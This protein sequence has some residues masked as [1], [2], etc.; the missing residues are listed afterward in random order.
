VGLREAALEA[1][2]AA[3][4]QRTATARTI[5]AARLEPAPVDGLTVI[6]TTADCVVFGDTDGLRLA[7]R[8]QT[9]PPRVTH[10]VGQPGEWTA[11]GEVASLTGLGLLIAA[12]GEHA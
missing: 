8:D 2:D 9:Q 5:L 3:R 6:D 7:V 11:R 10:V 4:E 12:D 1:A